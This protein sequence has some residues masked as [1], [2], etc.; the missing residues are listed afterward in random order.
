[1]CKG[2]ALDKSQ[3]EALQKCIEESKQANRSW[4]ARFKTG[5]TMFVIGMHASANRT[6]LAFDE[7]NPL[8]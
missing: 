8:F 2:M 4:F 5:L 3:R 7:K 6:P 1:M